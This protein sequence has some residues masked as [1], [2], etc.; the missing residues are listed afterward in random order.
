M[1]WI[2]TWKRPDFWESKYTR[3]SPNTQIHSGKKPVSDP[4]N[5]VWCIRSPVCFTCISCIYICISQHYVLW[6]RSKEAWARRDHRE[7]HQTTK[8]IVGA[9]ACIHRTSQRFGVIQPRR[10]PQGAGIQQRHRHCPSVRIRSSVVHWG[11]VPSI[12]ELSPTCT[13]QHGFNNNH[14]VQQWLRHRNTGTGGNQLHWK[15]NTVFTKNSRCG[16]SCEW[17]ATC[18]WMNIHS[19]RHCNVQCNFF[20]RSLLCSV[21]H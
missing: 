16:R 19:D 7:H 21:F 1:F 13:T 9:L 4:E 2:F 6:H 18:R 3:E 8:H 12:E 14:C 5:T 17:R 11:A 15:V 20:L 10:V